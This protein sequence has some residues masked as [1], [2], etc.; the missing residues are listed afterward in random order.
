MW[1]NKALWI[2]LVVFAKRTYKINLN[3]VTCLPPDLSRRALGAYN[4]LAYKSSEQQ[5]MGSKTLLKHYIN[6]DTLYDL[7]G[8]VIDSGLTELVSHRF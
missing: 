7:L 5:E 6:K 4:S 2:K 3:T 8:R 1:P